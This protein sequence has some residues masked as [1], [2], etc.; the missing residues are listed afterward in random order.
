[1][2]TAYSFRTLFTNSS[3][4]FKVPFSPFCSIV[5]ASTG[6][7]TVVSA[8]LEWTNFEDLATIIKIDYDVNARRSKSRMLTSLNGLRAHFGMYLAKDIT[9]D[10]LNSFIAHRLKEGLSPASVRIDLSILRRAFR[11]AE[12]AGKA[13]CPPL[14][15]HPSK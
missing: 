11:L 14:P 2:L 8:Q 15:H 10:R 13:V 4:V 7:H 9:F 5:R 12:R 1:V 3:A 6:K